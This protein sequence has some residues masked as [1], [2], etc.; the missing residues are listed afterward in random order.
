M[1]KSIL[2][3]LCSALIVPGLGQI[4]NQEIKKGGL[5]LGAVFFLFVAGSIKLVFIL[6]SMVSQSGIGPLVPSH[7]LER[8][9]LLLILGA[10]AVIWLYS[11]LDAFLKARDRER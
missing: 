5:I 2:A 4:M 10:F 7:L 9:D 11:V 3:P 8:F 1:K 6:K